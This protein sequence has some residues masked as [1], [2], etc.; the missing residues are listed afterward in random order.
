MA[1]VAGATTVKFSTLSYYPLTGYPAMPLSCIFTVAVP[2]GDL[3]STYD[4]NLKTSP[5]P[6]PWTGDLPGSTTTAYGDLQEAALAL[7][8]GVGGEILFDVYRICAQPG[9]PAQGLI[10]DD[11]RVE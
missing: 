1:V 3:L 2:N 5:L 9:G 6:K 8:S 10:V 11:L 7:P 4:I